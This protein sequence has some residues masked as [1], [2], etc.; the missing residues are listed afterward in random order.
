VARPDGRDG[1]LSH[2]VLEM[3][4]TFRQR[5]ANAFRITRGKADFRLRRKPTQGIDRQFR[6]EAGDITTKA[7]PC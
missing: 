1:Q 4:K 5:L 2:S 6:H 3:A 7:Q